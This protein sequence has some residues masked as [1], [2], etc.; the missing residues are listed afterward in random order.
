M[1]RK[2]VRCIL[3]LNLHITDEFVMEIK[4]FFGIVRDIKI[5][6][7]HTA[8]YRCHLDTEWRPES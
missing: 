7:E 5:H 1:L 4:A 3:Y 6:Y 2:T 8:H